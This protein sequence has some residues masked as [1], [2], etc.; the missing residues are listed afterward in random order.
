MSHFCSF[1]KHE[2]IAKAK[3]K[4]RPKWSKTRNP[5]RME[6]L[7]KRMGSAVSVDLITGI[8]TFRRRVPNPD[9]IYEA[10]LDG[11]YEGISRIIPWDKLEPDLKPAKD[12]LFK[13]LA[14]F[15]KLGV[16]A[17][18][19]PDRPEFRYDYQ[20]PHIQKIFNRRAGD[21]IVRIGKDTRESIKEIVHTQMTRGTSPREM[22]NQIKNYIGLYPRLANAHANYVQ[23]LLAS[24]MAPAT[25]DKLSERYY[26]KLLAY[27][28]RMIARTETQFMLNRG[29]LEV[30][31]EGMRQG[32]IPAEATK[33]W[34]VDGDPCPICDEMD[35]EE[36]GVH[37][38]WVL[39]DGMEVD[40]PTE[41]HPH[42]MCLMTIEF[43]G[44]E[45]TEEGDEGD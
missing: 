8:N 19:K 22:A 25:V 13:G 20:N 27:R 18:K 2:Y 28:S 3:A 39:P 30:W 9:R 44:A 33:V 42:C 7:S 11:K 34:V 10:W 23:G 16:E 45:T 24:K 36:V 1:H 26:D 31:K 32:L 12:Q 35:G 38:V 37:D 15:G 17:I 5:K 4:K 29:Q 40:I 41:V 6:A 43:E 21:Q 14:S